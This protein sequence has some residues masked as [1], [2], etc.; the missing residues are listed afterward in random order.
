MCAI[1]QARLVVSTWLQDYIFGKANSSGE[2]MAMTT[3]VFTS[4]AGAMQFVVGKAGKVGFMP[5]AAQC[6]VATAQR[7]AGWC[8]PASRCGAV[9][10]ELMSAVLHLRARS[11]FRRQ[12]TTVS[13][14]SS[15][16]AGTTPASPSAA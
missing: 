15:S 5:K 10:H 8:V 16:L 13:Q 11:S 9:Y 2:K 7:C 6:A 12:Q 1:I 4:S 3:P 14:S